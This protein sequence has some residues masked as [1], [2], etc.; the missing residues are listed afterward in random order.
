MLYTAGYFVSD[1]SL[2]IIILTFSYVTQM[3]RSG[4]SFLVSM[5][6]INETFV[7]MPQMTYLKK[8]LSETSGICFLGK[9]KLD[10]TYV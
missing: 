8:C 6:T 4:S 9:T 1:K 3:Q 7:V 10:E 2:I 5:N